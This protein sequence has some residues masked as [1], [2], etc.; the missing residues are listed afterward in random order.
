[1]RLKIRTSDSSERFGRL[2]IIQEGIKSSEFTVHH[3]S[4]DVAHVRVQK[5][6]W[7][8]SNDPKPIPL[9]KPDRTVVRT[10]NK[11][12]LYGL[13]TFLASSRQGM[14][15]HRASNS[16]AG[17]SWRSHIRTIRHMGASASLIH[18]QIVCAHNRVFVF[19]HEDFVVLRKPI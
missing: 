5:S 13:E 18:T 8:M 14:G 15:A 1:M 7:K 9:P 12:E 10:N 11:V 17:G 16:T 2:F 19:R 3:I 6:F 4:I